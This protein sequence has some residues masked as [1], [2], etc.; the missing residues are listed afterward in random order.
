MW[1]AQFESSNFLF[2]G[3]GESP[4]MAKHT[5]LEVLRLHC[6]RTKAKLKDFYYPEE[7]HLREL[8]PGFGFIDGQECLERAKCAS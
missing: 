1:L 6:K 5:L 2:E 3:A 4:A 8:Q 7:V